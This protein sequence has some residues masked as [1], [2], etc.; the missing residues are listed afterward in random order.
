MGV[1]TVLQKEASESLGKPATK[2]S[3]Y[4][5]YAPGLYDMAT[6]KVLSYAQVV[7]VL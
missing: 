6:N 1:G 5:T 3:I 2:H 4:S 7:S